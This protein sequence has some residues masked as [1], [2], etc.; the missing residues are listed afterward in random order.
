[1]DVIVLTFLF[2]YQG[3]IECIIKLLQIFVIVYAKLL[4]FIM[5]YIF[6]DAYHQH[7]IF[8]FTKLINLYLLLL[9]CCLNFYVLKLNFLRLLQSIF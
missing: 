3:L 7:S 4:N 8:R 2:K 1:M 6:L 5:F 9:Q